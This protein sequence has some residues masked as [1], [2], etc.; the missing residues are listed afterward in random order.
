ME[1]WLDSRYAPI[2]L[3][4][5]PETYGDQE[6]F[7]AFDYLDEQVSET[8]RRQARVS[9]LVDVTRARVGNATHRQ[10]ISKT[11]ARTMR[12]ASSCVVGQAFVVRT[13]MQQGAL[14]A[15]LWLVK[16]P[17]PL[18]VFSSREEAFD[19]LRRLHAEES[20]RARR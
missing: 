15:I 1:R 4:E 2:W 11:F 19:W 17:W 12:V 20:I 14:T 5:F 18:R 6:L 3:Q 9:L 8:A 10:R 16:P 7:S 13:R